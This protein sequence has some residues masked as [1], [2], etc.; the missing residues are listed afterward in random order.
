M[1]VNRK[2]MVEFLLVL[3]LLAV[4]L[5]HPGG[6]E[7]LGGCF[8]G[9]IVVVVIGVLLFLC[10]FFETFRNVALM[11]LILLAIVWI[12]DFFKSK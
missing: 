7:C 10:I 12:A 6:G 5:L 2:N 11:I 9:L 8:T 4:V 1:L 3:I